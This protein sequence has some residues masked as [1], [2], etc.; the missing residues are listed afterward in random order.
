[1]VALNSD[2]ELS[3]QFLGTLAAALDA[4]PSAGSACGRLNRAREG[5]G[6]QL[7][8]TGLVPDR[9]RRFHD[10]DHNA[11]DRGQRRRPGPVFGGSGSAVM[12][13]RAMLDDVADEGQFFDEDFFAYCEDADL[14]WR[15]QRRGWKSIFVPEAGG[16]HAHDEVTRARSNRHGGDAR[17]RQLLLMRNRHLCFLKNEPWRDLAKASPL[18][19]AYDAAL[20]TYLL[21]RGSRLSLNWPLSLVRQLPSLARKRAREFSRARVDV[22]LS[23]WFDGGVEPLAG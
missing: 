11:A 17:F 18:L 22:R 23:D 15:A 2:V 10:R 3:S 21:S 16:W 5:A 7:D 6:D 4:N 13:R 9:F 12:L 1:V 14:A 20:Q 19:L 8:S